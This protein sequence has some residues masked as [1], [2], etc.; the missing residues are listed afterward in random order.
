M[1]RCRSTGTILLLVAA[2]LLATDSAVA[3]FL[4]HSS[5][6]RGYGWG[7]YVS[8]RSSYVNR[9]VMEA[10]KGADRRQQ[11]A[12]NAQQH[13]SQNE[14]LLDQARDLYWNEL[15]WEHLTDEERLG[16]DL[17]VEQAFP[18]FLA[19][20][21]GLLLKEVMP[22]ALAPATPRPGMV[23]DVLAFLSA[24]LEQRRESEPEDGEDLR[25]AAEI[26][27]TTT[28]IDLVLGL[29]YG[30]T[31]EEMDRVSAARRAG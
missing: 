11:L 9:G 16:D 2:S 1:Q 5:Y 23:A 27:M 22:D 21:R 19:F 30:L 12:L 18:G 13:R 17:L 14:F 25:I 29:L 8:P 24:E 15:E 26:A 4:P 6:G 3:Q 31:P 28:L 10:Q 7:P 20:V